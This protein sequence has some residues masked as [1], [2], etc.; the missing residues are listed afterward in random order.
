[1]KTKLLLLITFTML[2]STMKTQAQTPEGKKI[3]IVYFSQSGN[4]EII[5]RQ[6]QKATDGDIFRLET[7]TPYPKEYQALVDQAKKEIEAGYKPALKEKAVNPESYDIIFA[8]SPSWW[9]TIAPA[10]ST[11]LSAYDFAGKT[12][13]PFITHEG[14]RMGRA[15]ADIKKLS[16]GATV[17][18]GLPVRGSSVQS[19]G[20]EV[21]KWVNE[22]L[23]TIASQDMQ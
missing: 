20:P 4:T 9:S 13:I 12:I 2:F 23:K 1:M 14:S 16:P 22:T 17:L 18:A 15:G 10:V 7:A 11:F 6:I 8:G 5:A 21:N 19:A 3:L